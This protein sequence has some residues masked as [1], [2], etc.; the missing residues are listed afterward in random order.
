VAEAC[1]LLAE[2]NPLARP[3]AGCTILTPALLASTPQIRLA[4]DL[5]AVPELAEI[6]LEHGVLHVGAGT[7]L[8]RLAG[9][10][11]VQEA[12]P[13]LV[14]A[15]EQVGDEVIRALATLGGNVATCA[16]LDLPVALAAI[17]A[18]VVIAS[19]GG[20]R[21]ARVDAIHGPEWLLRDDELVTEVVVQA[22][23]GGARWRW[24]KL[25]THLHAFGVASV[26]I[27]EVDGERRVAIGAGVPAPQ[28]LPSAEPADVDAL[29]IASDALASSGYRRRVLRALVQ[30]ELEEL[31]R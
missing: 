27:H 4:V 9:D 18:S 19:T 25:T 10:P 14:A 13:L 20:A 17:G 1:A 26:A 11:L 21:T 6:R 12:A 24:R 31:H 8:A 5:L 15:A 23:N 28:L 29:E 3:V 22:S 2:A 30:Q 7:T 16:P